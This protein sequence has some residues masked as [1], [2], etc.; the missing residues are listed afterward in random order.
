MQVVGRWMYC[1]YCERA[2][3]SDQSQFCTYADCRH[4]GCTCGVSGILEWDGIQELNHYPAI[5][6]PGARYPLIK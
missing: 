4:H 2:F 3:Q 1:L 6:V 5:P